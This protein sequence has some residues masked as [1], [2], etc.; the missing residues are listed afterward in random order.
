MGPINGSKN[1]LTVKK[2]CIFKSM[3]NASLVIPI[4]LHILQ[5]ATKK[6]MLK[7]KEDLLFLLSL[8]GVFYGAGEK[9][10]RRAKSGLGFAFH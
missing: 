2:N 5:A 3:S 1:K 7:L 8:P 9:P 6:C 10:S 4:F